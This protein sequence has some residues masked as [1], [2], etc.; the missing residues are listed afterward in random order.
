MATPSVAKYVEEHLTGDE[1]L[2]L[3]T[4]QYGNVESFVQDLYIALAD[5]EL[6]TRTAASV[7]TRKEYE[8]VRDKVGAIAL[9][10]SFE[11]AKVLN[12][13]ARAQREALKSISNAN[14]MAFLTTLSAEKDHVAELTPKNI[15]SETGLARLHRLAVYLKG[16]AERVRKLEVN[17]GRD[18][19]SSEELA[20]A[21]A[22]FEAAGGSVPLPDSAGSELIQAR[23]LIEELRVSLFA[24]SLGTSESVSVQRIKK[25]FA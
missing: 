7:F 10:R 18:R 13:I 20:K 17:P 19:E 15:L 4:L 5:Q 1:K 16:V 23:W 21:I 11:V 9:E 12:D 24:Q 25:L 14:A 6:R 3:A 8:A 22:F 2:A